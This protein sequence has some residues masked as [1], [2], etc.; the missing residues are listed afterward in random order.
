MKRRLLLG[1]ALGLAVA[2]LY[3]ARRPLQEAGFPLDPYV[4]A[5]VAIPVVLL[6]LRKISLADMGLAGVGRVGD[7]LFFVALLPGI[8]YLRL[9]LM[10]IPFALAPFAF[11]LIIGSLA[12]EFFFRGY[13]Q[14]DFEKS[15][16]ATT[17][18]ILTNAL[19]TLVHVVKGYS[20]LPSLVIFAIGLYF[21]FA[22]HEK[23][24]GS[25]VYPMA[26]HVLYNIV[27]SSM[28]QAGSWF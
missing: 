14:K 21:S 19:F 18:F 17:S 2:A 27:A 22:R 3:A 20:A 10:G 28:P 23:G 9:R 6:A 25:L 4:T 1:L 13:L 26:A 8:L 5:L 16:N 24:G 11:S 7:G 12:E 15:S